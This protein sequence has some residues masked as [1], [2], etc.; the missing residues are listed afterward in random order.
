[1]SSGSLKAAGIALALALSLAA[2]LRAATVSPIGTNQRTLVI[3][4]RY[5][6]AMTTRMA[7]CGE[8]VTLLNAETN[9]FYNQ[10]TFNQTNFQFETISGPTAPADGWLDLPY[11]SA[12][13][14]FFSTGQDAIDLADP[15]ADFAN[16]DR[17]VV[18]TSWPGFGGQGGG[19]WWW[20]V[21]EGAEATVTPAVGGAAVPSRLMTLSITNEWLADS[22][23]NP[24]D[25]GGAVTAHELGHQLGAPT[26]YGTIFESGVTRD[27]ITWW[28]IMGL[29]PSLNHFLGYPK[30]D[31]GWIPAGPRIVTLGPLASSGAIDQ[32]VTLHPLEQT[33]AGAQV[34]RIPFASVSPFVGYM[35]EN[36][37]RI[38]GDE[39]LASEGVLLSLVDQSGTVILHAFVLEDPSEPLNLDQAPLEV[40]E[41]FTDTA[42]DLTVTVLSQSGND[43]D[44]RVQYDPPATTFDPAVT[45]WGAPPWETTDIWL[46]SQRNMF[47]TYLYTDAAGN[48]VG[49]GDDA[50]VDHDNRV[51]VRVHNYG[52]AAASNVRVQVY[53]NSPPGMG[54]AGPDW[55]YLGT[56]L[57]PSIAG[58][59]EAR[60][61]VLWNPTVAAHT[62]I[63]AVIVD[64]PGE[65]LTTN[66]LAQ[67]NVTHFDTSAGSPYQAVHLDANV[68]N[69]YDEELAVHMHVRDVP[70]GWAVVMEPPDLRIPARGKHPVHV[71]VYPS[72]LPPRDGDGAAGGGGLGKRADCPPRVDWDPERLAETTRPGFV[73]KPKI[74][75]QIPFFDTFVPIGGIEAWTRLTR[76]TRLTCRV[77]G[78]PEP[79]PRRPQPSGPATG[80][81]PA[82]RG[83]PERP[84][85]A[86][87][88]TL[89]LTTL[90]ELGSIVFGPTP[91]PW[92]EGGRAAI[93]GS[94]TPAVAGAVIAVEVTQAGKSEVR[95]ARTDAQGRYSISLEGLRGRATVQAFFDG[96]Q[97]HGE[98]QSGFCGVEAPGDEGQPGQGG[99]GG[100][101]PG[102]GHTG[103]EGGGGLESRW[104][105]S[106]HGGVNDPRRDLGETCDGG[107]SWGV[108]AEFRIDAVWA[109]ELFYGHEDLDCAQKDRTIDHL[110]L[111][112]KAYLAA[113]PWRPFVGIGAGRYDFDPGSME[114]GFNVFGGLQV[115]PWP[116]LG[117]E[118]TARYHVVDA[119]GANDD[120]LTY[121]LGLRIRF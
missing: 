116:R 81:A 89:D 87:A 27:T 102:G 42:H 44:V 54:D 2:G 103:L 108:D 67:E 118:A 94:L 28:D 46:D 62:C 45:P 113:G 80:L 121:H 9:A 105:L 36:R 110:S 51:Y 50:W 73:G 31:R 96:D 64:T 86:P 56:I 104:S 20:A 107:A 112:G 115:N 72:G 40:G 84:G 58:G 37:R 82:T 29:S 57:M 119:S 70:Y 76:P 101:G 93:E 53:V 92:A 95:F 25:E 43:Y 24:F 90:Q 106:L 38:Q 63:K 78:A 66:N 85:A 99:G 3:C 11:G 14:D 33:T 8:W 1:M 15:Y 69:P 10:A 97:E 7:S 39:R 109:A 16:Y 34:I 60:G 91:N 6:D 59:G 79:A 83:A 120:F 19:P 18:M 32:T 61:F 111:H 68:Y 71:A 65:V 47:D 74:E 100:T 55:A 77:V 75:A 52:T 117:V 30:V 21:G 48:P 26:H 17:V 41:S 23:G 35:V 88:T 22:F 98:A 13:Y 12:G 49:N 4:V 114:T 5:T